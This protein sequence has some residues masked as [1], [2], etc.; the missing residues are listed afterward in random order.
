MS[1]N[2][3]SIQTADHSVLTSTPHNST[4]N[5]IVSDSITVGFFDGVACV[6]VTGRGSSKNSV[7]VKVFVQRMMAR[8]TRRFVVDLAQCEAMDSTFMGMLTGIALRLEDLGDGG[9]LDVINASIRSRQLLE[10][11]GLD[12]L[13]AIHCDGA[14]FAFAADKP[15]ESAPVDPADKKQHILEAHEALIQADKSNEAK[16]RDVVEFLKNDTEEAT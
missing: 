3:Q 16:F 14:G 1:D 10:D 13:F 5:S 11:L 4:I 6:R 8:G 9:Q 7:D 15:L 2:R 12:A